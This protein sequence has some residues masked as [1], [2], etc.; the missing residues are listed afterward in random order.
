MMGVDA[1]TA[2]PRPFHAMSAPTGAICNLGCEYCF[3]LA[4][5][6]LYPGGSSRM[7]EDVLE[8]YVV[9]LLE[10]QAGLAEV[11]IAFEGGGPTR[12]GSLADARTLLQMVDSP[13]QTAFGTATRDSLPQCFRRCD[14][15]FACGGCCPKDRLIDAPGGEAGLNWF[16]SGHRSF[17]RHIDAPMRTMAD[18]VPTGSGAADVMGWYAQHQPDPHSAAPAPSG[19]AP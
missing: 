16:C 15:G 11:V 10:A 2:V 7:P 6:S 12:V 4:D 5:E 14:V 18:V 9:G 3:Y 1:W 17:F 19:G 8:G 13:K